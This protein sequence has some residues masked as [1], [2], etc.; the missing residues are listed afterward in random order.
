MDLA[1]PKRHKKI[2]LSLTYCFKIL[3]SRAH[4]WLS[5]FLMFMLMSVDGL[6]H[7]F[8]VP[9]M[10]GWWVPVVGSSAAMVVTGKWVNYLRTLPTWQLFRSSAK[11]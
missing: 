2:V 3:G 1:A 9:H 7:V 5:L 11:K 10:E 4:R 8:N 6:M